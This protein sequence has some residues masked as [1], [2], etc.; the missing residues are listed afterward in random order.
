MDPFVTGGLIGAGSDLLGGIMGRNSAK[1]MAGT[2]WAKEKR[3]IRRRA[4]DAR[5]AGI[6]PLAALGATASYGPA[7]GGDGGFGDSIGR[8]GGAIADAYAAKEAYKRDA[9]L[10]N[11][12]MELLDA[13]ILESR[14]RTM[15]NAA[16]AR[17]PIYGPRPKITGVTSGLEGLDPG[18]TG[19]PRGERVEPTPNL[20]ARQKVSLGGST[21]TGPNPEAFEVGLSE[22]IAGAMIYGPQ[23]A[24]D[25]LRE[26]A[27]EVSK[28]RPPP[29]S[30]AG[31]FN[32]GAWYGPGSSPR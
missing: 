21:A 26:Y 31:D 19:K 28:R 9:P 24:A 10:R 16:N 13:Q 22:L 11:K 7:Q 12:E 6:H 25:H 2:Y 32:E 5:A 30:R 17:R 1:A 27:E 18:E 4:R 15:L 8:A 29:R 14:S 3:F 23:W 20:G